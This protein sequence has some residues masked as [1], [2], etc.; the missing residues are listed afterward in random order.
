M[1]SAFRALS[2]AVFL[3]FVGGGAATLDAQ[4][5][6]RGKVVD[7]E[8]GSG[9]AGATVRVGKDGQAITTDS[10]GRFILTGLRKGTAEVLIMAI[11]YDSSTFEVPIRDSGTVAGA[12]PLD[13][14]GY[15]LSPIVIQARAEALMPRYTDF[16]G[17]RQRKMG[18][19]L[20]WDDI[21]KAGFNTVGEAL[22]SVRGVRIE[23][24]QAEFE[25][26]AVMVRTPQCHP[27]WYVDGVEVRSFN[28]S[29]PIRDVYGI[30][31]PGRM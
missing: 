7:S 20:R 21:K 16:E 15:M 5:T 13:F 29:T 9:I 24:N 11:G 31:V 19:Y 22:R 8:I 26:A 1:T 17:R 18:A 3:T 2:N 30:E 10:L 23:C 27:T 25:C 6:L 28:E 12:F 14:N 4:T